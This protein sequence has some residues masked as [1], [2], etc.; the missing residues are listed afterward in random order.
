[1]ASL[2]GVAAGG[3]VGKSAP[4]AKPLEILVHD[5]CHAN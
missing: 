4:G 3:V 1:V 5:V 2:H